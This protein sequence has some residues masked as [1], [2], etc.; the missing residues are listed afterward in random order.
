M[1][2]LQKIYEAGVVGAGGAGFPTHIKLNCQVEYFIINAAECEPLL[3][4]DKYLMATKSEEMIKAIEEVSKHIGAKHLIIAI[5]KKYNKEIG[6]LKDAIERLNSKVQLFYLDNYYPAGD[7]QM[8]VY[9]VT[10]RSIPEAGIPL[11]VGAVVSNVGT[12]VNIHDA[13]K[14]KPVTE[15]YITVVGEVKN[16]IMIKV[17]VG[18]SI[19]ECIEAAGGSTIKDY[20]IIIGGPMMGT[21]I[22]DDESD[23]NYIK[24]TDGSLIVLPKDHYIVERKRKPLKTIINETRSACIQCRYCT[25]LCHRYLIGHKLRPHK[26]MRNIGMSEHDAEIMKEA[27]ICCECGIC[28]LYSCPMGLSPRLVNTYIKGELRKGGIRPEKGSK[29]IESREMIEY[30]KIPTTRL[31]ARLDI[32]KYYDQKLDDVKELLPKKV[33]I[34]LS[35]HIGK[36]AKAIV[37]VGDNVAKDQLIGQIERNDMGANIH[38]TIDGKVIEVSDKIV[39]LKEDNGVIS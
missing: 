1:D 14:D 15:K 10:G 11:D 5:K 22:D 25:D 17:P 3:N 33:S 26:I 34:P 18:I 9:E 35:Q 29:D 2:L 19:K 37:S 32:L 21:I 7:E 8:M 24:K 23:E 16:P 28:E 13:M 27:L 4:T 36:P 39:I 30:R 20:A 12:L 6:I 38:A 31:M